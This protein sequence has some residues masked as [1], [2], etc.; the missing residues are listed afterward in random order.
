[1]AIAAEF[2]D[3]LDKAWADASPNCIFAVDAGGRITRFNDAMALAIGLPKK[4]AMGTLLAKICPMHGDNVIERL[5]RISV[6]GPH[7]VYITF[8][9]D[10]GLSR[11]HKTIELLGCVQPLRD[12]TGNRLSLFIGKK[13]NEGDPRDP[14]AAKLQDVR[15]DGLEK[16][17]DPRS[18][19]PSLSQDPLEIPQQLNVLHKVWFVDVSTKLVNTCLFVCCR[20]FKTRLRFLRS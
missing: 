2:A 7:D 8:R 15:S 5:E 4:E 17:Q 11:S 16:H 20:S 6:N 13:V 19:L 1:M 3:K 18:L 14:L 10:A 9:A 12:A